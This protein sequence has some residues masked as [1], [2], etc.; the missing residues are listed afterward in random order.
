MTRKLTPYEYYE[1]IQVEYL[2]AVLRSK[3]YKSSEDR[4]FWSR[5]AEGKRVKIDN[6]SEK[7]NLPSIFTD[8]DMLSE[9]ENRLY[10]K[11]T[12]P[13]FVY[14]DETHRL[15]QEPFDLVY[16]YHKGSE[17][18][19]LWEGE[20]KIGTILNTYIPGQTFVWI[21]DRLDNKKRKVDISMVAR[22]M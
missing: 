3:I 22:T 13:L 6:I 21:V 15:E 20:V 11:D 16:Y 18:R 8:T 14:R 9:F 5:V 4:G 10:R 19:Y 1:R 12:Y 17:I 2:C 7:N